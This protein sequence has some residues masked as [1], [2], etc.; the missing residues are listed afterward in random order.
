[1]TLTRIGRLAAASL[2]AISALTAVSRAAAAQDA[3]VPPGTP[4][5]AAAAP[6]GFDVHGTVEAAY[7]FTDITGSSD[8]Y[9]QLIDL[10]DGLRL[11]GFDLE[12][13]PK[14]TGRGFADVFSISASGFGGDPFPAVQAIARKSGLY[15]LRINWRKSRF[16]DV[17]PLTPPSIAGLDTRAVTDHHGW[18]TSRQ[19][20]N[21]SWTLHVTTHLHL[22]FDYDRM[23]RDGALDSTRALDFLGSPSAWGSFARANPYPV[24]VPVSDT[25]NRVTAGVSYSRGPW[26]VN[27]KAGYQTYDE[28][29]TINSTTPSELGINVADPATANELLS[30]VA[31]SQSRRLTGPISE[32]SFLVQPSSKVEWRG[33]Y[34]Y[35]R[36]DGPFNLDGGFRGIARTNSTGTTLSPYDVTISAR[37]D[38]TA[39]SHVVG[40]GVTYRP[41]D[42]WAFDAYYRYSRF[43]SDATG[44]LGSLLALYP[45]ATAT[46]P[47]ASSEADDMTWRIAT[48]EL[49]LAATFEPNRKLTIRPG[50]R[51]SRRDVERR[52]NDVV[53]PATS[54]REKMA[55]PQ[56]MV[57]YRPI[58]QVTMRGSITNSYSDATFTRLSPAE[59]DVSRASIRVEP[60]PG[61]AIDASVN[62]TD[63]DL[64]T[65][66]FVS[67]TR[68]GS[69]QASYAFGERLTLTGGLDYQSFLGLGD[70]SFLRGVSP[71]ADNLMSDREVDRVW[72]AGA[73]VKATD[74]LGVSATA[75]FDRTTGTDTIAGEPP[76][77]GPVTFPYATGTIYYE[78]PRVGRVSIDLQR[79]YRFE[80]VLPLNNFRA[81][82]LMIRFS[83]AF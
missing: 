59:R 41:F 48:H 13:R 5:A 74:H 6:A 40:Q 3:A 39:P 9:R 81:S 27:Y 49:T 63:A 18:N 78:V 55:S 67:H 61:L 8:T 58:P 77:Y 52:I 28:N 82:L 22:L 62:R 60:L 75:N 20:G 73:I 32:L 30:T 14:E 71:V 64:L 11:A 38:A 53:D 45:P 57:T 33:E 19:I 17:S 42:G 26:R 47:V 21:A 34:T 51:L 1:M 76:L 2:V 15:D 79:T 36:Y 54:D 12:G 10:S 37:G 70:V 80:D 23:S 4:L 83:R 44:Q 66:G 29:E 24:V 56:L 7:R 31:W 25:S 46:T 69:I 72:Q 35:S 43:A 68:I 16:F 65:D 50:V